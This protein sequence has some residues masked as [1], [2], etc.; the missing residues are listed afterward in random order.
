MP[1]SP[2][3]DTDFVRDTD[4]RAFEVWL[5]IQRSRTPE[6]K[7]RDVFD[8]SEGLFAWVKAGVTTALVVNTRCTSWR[9]PWAYHVWL[10]AG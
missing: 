4:P 10:G 8:L 3:A 7:L 9:R 2:H 5:K 1:E 6:E